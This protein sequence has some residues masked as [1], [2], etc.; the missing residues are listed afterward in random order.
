MSPRKWLQIDLDE[1]NVATVLVVEGL[2]DCEMF[3]QFISQSALVYLSL[4]IPIPDVE[5][6]LCGSSAVFKNAIMLQ[7]VNS[8]DA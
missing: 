7:C 3:L 1:H 4:H 8:S 5:I 2:K 6:Y